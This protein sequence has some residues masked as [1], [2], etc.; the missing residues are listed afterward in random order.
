MKQRPQE[1]LARLFKGLDNTPVMGAE[2]IFPL[3]RRILV[4]VA[5]L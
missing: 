2:I 4:D 3:Q 5:G 1:R